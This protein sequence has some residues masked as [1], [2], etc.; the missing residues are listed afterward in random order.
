MDL[1]PSYPPKGGILDDIRDIYLS[2]KL[3]LARAVSKI[4]PPHE[5][6]DVVQETYVRLCQ[7]DAPEKIN[8]PKSYLYKTA[9]N[10]ALDSLKRADNRITE[11]W[12]E[13]VDVNGDL[14]RVARD[15]TFEQAASS[16]EFGRFCE[17]VR[18]LPIQARRVFV[19]KKVYGYSQREIASELGLAESTVEKHVA[20]AIR[21][22]TVFMCERQWLESSQDN[23]RGALGE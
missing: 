19:L 14:F 3:G 22:C 23:R 6:E 11:S 1:R 18:Q 10:L 17:A 16:E 21:R 20:L 8:N 9:R 4:V 12:H 15:E 2:I 7:V 13:E 5:V